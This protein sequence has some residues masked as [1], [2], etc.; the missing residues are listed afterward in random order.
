MKKQTK[1]HFLL[2]GKTIFPFDILITTASDI[3][4]HKYVEKTKHYKFSEGEKRDLE[5]EGHGRTC[6]LENGATIIRLEK[7]KNKIGIDIPTLTH[8]I[9]HAVFFI[10][11]R[12]GITHTKE[13]DEIFS[14]YQAYVMKEAL[15][16]FDK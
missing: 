13:S 10:L 3:E 11:N 9:E 7:T 12:V 1:S 5:M 8:E 16:Y 4:L 6:M 14:Y 2:I 15:D